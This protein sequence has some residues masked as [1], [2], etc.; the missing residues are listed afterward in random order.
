MPRG[1]GDRPVIL[2][3]GYQMWGLCLGIL[4]LWLRSMGRTVITMPDFGPG[5]A[6]IRHFAKRLRDHIREVLR[7]TGADA[8]DLVGHSM[9]GLIARACL[10]EA[11]RSG[12]SSLRVAHLVTLGTPHKGTCFWVFTRGECGLDMKPGSSFLKWL[13]EDPTEENATI[14]WSD[15]DDIVHEESA[16][17]W[18]ASTVRKI[19]VSGL[20]HLA[21]S[22]LPSAAREVFEAMNR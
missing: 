6:G 18:N 8:V 21:L 5:S 14:I 12:D 7:E 15:L 2:C 10:T 1:P 13:G 19:H 11:R 17:G 3:H 4:A 22:M 9:G 16:K 20:G